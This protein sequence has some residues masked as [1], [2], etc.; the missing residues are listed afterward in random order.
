MWYTED[1]PMQNFVNIRCLSVPVFSPQSDVSR[2]QMILFFTLCVLNYSNSTRSVKSVIWL[3]LPS[4]STVTRSWWRQQCVPL[5]AP[6][7]RA[8]VTAITR[9]VSVCLSVCLSVSPSLRLC[10]SASLNL[11][12]LYLSFC[13]SLSVCLSLFVSVSLSLSLV[14]NQVLAYIPIILCILP[15]WAS[16]I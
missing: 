8:S 15:F 11:S 12:D 14:D 5:P 9:K 16:Y 6:P 2:N 10:L 4:C 7:Q 1:S 3:P 13:V